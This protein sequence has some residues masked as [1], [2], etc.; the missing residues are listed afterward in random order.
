ML[1]VDA[2]GSGE[3]DFKEF[4]SL[5]L[6]LKR[7]DTPDEHLERVFITIAHELA[8][9]AC[10]NDTYARAEVEKRQP[11]S[12]LYEELPVEVLKDMLCREGPEPLDEAEAL[13]MLREADADGN[14]SVSL[15]ELRRALLGSS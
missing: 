14:G 5:L 10:G 2:D 7:D 6:K 9:D 11:M 12:Y 1:A 3:L 15:D 8:L 13:A 4:L